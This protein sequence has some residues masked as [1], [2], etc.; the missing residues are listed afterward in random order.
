MHCKM[1]Q[2]RYTMLQILTN[3]KSTND[4]ILNILL[5]LYDFLHSLKRTIWIASKAP[6][7]SDF[8]GLWQSLKH[9]VNN[10]FM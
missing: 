4:E 8:R 5:V 2:K 1:Q 3:M 7:K 10:G 9:F 6:G